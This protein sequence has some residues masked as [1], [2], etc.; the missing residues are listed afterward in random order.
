[1]HGG[2]VAL[3]IRRW[4]LGPVPEGKVQAQFGPEGQGIG[5]FWPSTAGAL[6]NDSETTCCKA[7]ATAKAATGAATEVM[8][9]E[10]QVWQAAHAPQ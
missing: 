10:W 1:M 3:I 7:E 6:A 4:Q 5:G 8:A 2:Q 9:T